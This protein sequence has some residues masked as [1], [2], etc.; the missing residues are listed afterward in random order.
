MT[1]APT[2]PPHSLGQR[3]D[4]AFA[5]AVRAVWL[6]LP[7]PVRR[8]V[9]VSLVGFALINGFTFAV[10]LGL[11]AL[12]YRGAGLPHPVAITIGYAAAFGLAFFLNRRFNFHAHGPVTGQVARW[13]LVVAVNYVALVLGLGSG[14]HA[15]GVPF[16]LARLVAAGAEAA[17]MYS[18]MR[19]WV[20]ADRAAPIVSAQQPLVRG[21]DER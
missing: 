2:F 14:L 16:L 1:E 5:R 7:R 15:A 3:I 18:T 20:F 10:D 4:R 21:A 9:P 19:W 17:W 13:V 11:L 12:L 8:R 6:L